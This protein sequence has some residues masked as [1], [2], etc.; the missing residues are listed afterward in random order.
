MKRL[1]ILVDHAGSIK[2][3]RR[4]AKKTKHF[5]KRNGLKRKR[6]SDEINTLKGAKKVALDCT[7]N[8]VTE[9]YKESYT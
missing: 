5:L 6:L 9:I 3:H 8:K 7:P 4:R 1:I 2:R